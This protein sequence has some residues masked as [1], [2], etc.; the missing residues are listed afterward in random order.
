M[1]HVP[2]RW[3]DAV[4]YLYPTVYDAEHGRRAGATGFIVN[5]PAEDPEITRA[6]VHH[7][8]VTNHHGVTGREETVLR[9]NLREGGTDTLTIPNSDWQPHP[10]GDDLAVAPLQMDFN[11]HQYAAV[12]LGMI[13]TQESAEHWDIG[14]G[15]EAFFI[16]RYVDLEGREHNVP[17]VRSGIVAAFPGQRVSQ[18]PRR[19]F[20][21]ESVLVEARSLSGFSGSPVF[22]TPAPFIKRS[23]DYGGAPA[24]QMMREAPVFLLGIDWG[25][26]PWDEPVRRPSGN[27]LSDGTYVRTNSGMMTV[28]PGVKLLE[29]LKC[30]EVLQRHRREVEEQEV[31]WQR[32]QSPTVGDVDPERLG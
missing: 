15:D 8:V 30:S 23:D 5:M 22:V 10:D 4:V 13:L 9:V 21:Q 3:L 19:D 11:T 14:P 28:V 1:P 7:Y 20:D 17:T 32:E 29:I 12:N 18:R 26:S 31:A 16:G 24:V 27:P 6:V 2:K 25:H